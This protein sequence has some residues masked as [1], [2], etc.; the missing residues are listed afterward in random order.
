MT[1][2]LSTS[3][4][5]G[6]CTKKIIIFL[7]KL[8]LTVG[9]IWWLLRGQ[10]EKTFRQLL[11]IAPVFLVIA[12]SLECF[13]HVIAAWRWQSL[14]R[15]QGIEISLWE[16]I[17][18]N[19][20]SFFYSLV[21]PG[22]ALGGDL[23]KVTILCARIPKGKRLEPASTIF[24]DRVVG[25]IGLF[26]MILVLSP[27]IFFH[28]S[29]MSSFGWVIVTI[30]L[31]ACLAGVLAGVGLFY[32]REL[33][34]IRLIG[35]LFGWLDVKSKGAWERLL[36]AFDI[37][38]TKLGYLFLWALGSMLLIHLPAIMIVVVFMW[39]LSMHGSVLATIF[40]AAAGNTAGVLP[41]LGGFGF[42]EATT[43][44]LLQ[45]LAG[46]PSETAL[47]PVLGYAAVLLIFNLL[48]GIWVLIPMKSSVT[49]NGGQND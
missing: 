1:S 41:S 12:F 26:M 23:I 18:L 4:K 37:Y 21:M 25:M 6:L 29:E 8:S 16:A 45:D 39:G 46:L 14:L 22:G 38:R 9:I 15:L 20:Q 27:L 42:R 43:D 32:H 36:S 47:L 17:I 3:Q 24:I 10:D 19:W 34:K 30:L 28:T 13:Q 35:R 40:S 48:G 5:I 31:P 49:Q 7:I 2:S 11:D 33:E 44:R